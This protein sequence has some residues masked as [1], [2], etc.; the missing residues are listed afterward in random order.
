MTYDWDFSIAHDLYTNF[1]S[2]KKHFWLQIYD[3]VQIPNI[4]LSF[5]YIKRHNEL[6]TDEGRLSYKS[7]SVVY[8]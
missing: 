8:V 7:E 6:Y 3:S 5:S 2:S 1:L 4:A